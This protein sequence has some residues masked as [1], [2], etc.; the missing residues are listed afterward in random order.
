MSTYIKDPEA[1]LDYTVSWASWLDTGETISTSAFTVPAGLTMDSESNN[2]TS[3]T[4]WLSGGTV[5]TAYTVTHRIT[6]S[7]G[8]TDDRSFIVDVRER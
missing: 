8:R 5:D 7:A 4:V 1:V 2:T 6:T 3:G